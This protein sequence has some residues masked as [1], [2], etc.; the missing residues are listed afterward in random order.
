MELFKELILG[1]IS[2]RVWLRRVPVGVAGIAGVGMMVGGGPQVIG[3]V[4]GAYSLGVAASVY[5]S[6][7]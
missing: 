6:L 5:L 3:R 4:I 7:S 1:E 2:R